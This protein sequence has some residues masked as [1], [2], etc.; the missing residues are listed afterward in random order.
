[1]EVIFCTS[2]K[3]HIGGTASVTIEAEGCPD[4]YS[5]INELGVRFGR[6]FEKLLLG[7]ESLILLN[8]KAVMTKGGAG[9]LLKQGDIIEVLP[10]IKAG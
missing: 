10:V 8:S 6:E 9:T 7:G 3:E 1:M 4:L 5:L 2:I